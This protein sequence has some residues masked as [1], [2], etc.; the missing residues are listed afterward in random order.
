MTDASAYHQLSIGVVVPESTADVQA[1]MSYCA[2]N[3]IPVFPRGG[4]TSLAGQA[5]NEAV[6]LDFKTRFNDIVEF[7]PERDTVTAQPGITSRSSW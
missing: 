2:D 1:V 5:V 6:V 7:N 3:G 4:G